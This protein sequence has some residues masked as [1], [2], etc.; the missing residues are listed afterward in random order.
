MYS[1]TDKR[2]VVHYTDDPGAIP[3]DQQPKAK[4]TSGARIET[5][6]NDAS[7]TRGNTRS[8]SGNVRPPSVEPNQ[9]SVPRPQTQAPLPA[10]TAAEEAR[11]AASIRN[12]ESAKARAQPTWTP[13]MEERLK[14]ERAQLERLQASHH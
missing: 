9:A 12:G 13:E 11:L 7:R 6:K 1:W 10:T 2:G 3:K 14:S 5:V 4:K 8:T